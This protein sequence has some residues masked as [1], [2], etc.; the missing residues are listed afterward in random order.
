MA[1]GFKLP[2]VKI[3]TIKELINKIYEDTHLN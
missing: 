1:Y 2:Q 3:F